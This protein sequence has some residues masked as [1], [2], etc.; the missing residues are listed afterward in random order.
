MVFADE[1]LLEVTASLPE[2]QIVETIV[3]NQITFQTA[4]A[5]KAAPVPFRGGRSGNSGRL[6]TAV[7]R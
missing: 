5:T 2:A 1:P 6:L 4:L 3:L 7:C